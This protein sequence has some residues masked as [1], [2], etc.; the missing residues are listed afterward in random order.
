MSSQITS[1]EHRI[2][3]RH[4]RLDPA[5]EVAAHPVGAADVDLALAAVREHEDA[6]VLEEAADD[7]AARG[8]SR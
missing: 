3:H 6:R 4:D 8:S 7:A 2:E 5:V 1:L